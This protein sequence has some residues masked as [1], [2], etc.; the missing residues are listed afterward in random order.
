MAEESSCPSLAAIIL[1]LSVVVRDE[2]REDPLSRKVFVFLNR[3]CDR[4]KLLYWD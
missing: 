1:T 3:Q 2:L 4:V